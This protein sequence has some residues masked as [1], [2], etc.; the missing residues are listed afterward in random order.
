MITITATTTA[1][2]TTITTII[3]I[4]IITITATTTTILKKIYLDQYPLELD[5]IDKCQFVHFET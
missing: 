4:I 2:T 3:T 5:I 1:T